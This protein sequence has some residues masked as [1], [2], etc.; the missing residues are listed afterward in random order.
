M[1]HDGA[2]RP[3][4]GR[5]GA[6]AGA[7]G[8]VTECLADPLAVEIVR[9][10]V[11]RSL[12]PALVLGVGVALAFLAAVWFSAPHLAP[13]LVAAAA[14]A[15]SFVVARAGV[16]LADGAA[17]GA[18]A[19]PTVGWLSVAGATISEYAVYAGLAAGAGL[20]AADRDAAVVWWLAVGAVLLNAARH[21]TDRCYERVAQPTAGDTAAP[22][23]LPRRLA[24]SL[25][26]PAGERV[27]LVAVAGPVAGPR[28]TFLALLGWGGV[29]F[30]V[31]LARRGAARWRHDAHLR[32]GGTQTAEVGR[33]GTDGVLVPY[34][35]DGPLARRLG[36]AV[37]GRLPPLPPAAVGVFVVVTLAA[38]G[39]GGVS[40]VLVL[41]PVAAMLLAGLGSTHPH[42]GPADWLVPPLL[43]AGECFFFALLAHR[44]DLP[45]PVVFALVAGVALRHLDVGYRAGCALT[46]QPSRVV[47]LG[48]DGRMVLAGAVAAFGPV[49]LAC[50][51]ACGYL[52]LVLGW[53]FLTGWLGAREVDRR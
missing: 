23:E 25:A 32:A 5:S 35:D 15:V 21:L 47:D 28:V 24:R 42:D 27:L 9:G 10:A 33:K 29:A 19:G 30:G 7:A 46:W 18:P 31:D 26:L 3:A 45:P 14:L 38:V 34:R 41:A 36:G 51:A 2:P 22:G 11:R 48:W 8:L 50:V 40:G 12:P 44:A 16:L 4:P 53:E 49:T 52:W 17:R 1:G 13:R 37:R 20:S 43:S 6:H 39:F